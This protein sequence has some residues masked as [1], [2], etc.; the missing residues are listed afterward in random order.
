MHTIFNSK[1]RVRDRL[2][3]TSQTL[4]GQADRRRTAQVD[5]DKK[6]NEARYNKDACRKRTTQFTLKRSTLDKSIRT[7]QAELQSKTDYNQDTNEEEYDERFQSRKNNQYL[8]TN[9][10]CS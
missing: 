9:V 5:T 3:K 6:L 4:A 10:S 1:Q 7:K 2:K 8:Q